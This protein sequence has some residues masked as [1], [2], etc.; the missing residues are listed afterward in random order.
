MSKLVLGSLCGLIFGA[1]VVATMVPLPF[2][3]KRAAMLGAFVNRFAI[4]FVL[5][6]ATLPLPPWATGLVFGFLLSLP[7]AIITKAYPPILGMGTLGGLIIG[8]VIGIWGV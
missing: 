1:I 7:D 2:D 3:D 8:V 6:T 4:G 5:G